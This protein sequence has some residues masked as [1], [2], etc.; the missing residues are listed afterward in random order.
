MTDPQSD[1][2]LVA[3]T[4]AAL[5]IG[6]EL[7]SG[8]TQE[9]NLIELAR[10]L[11]AI[12]I[13]LIRA[14]VVPDDID[15]IAA[16]VRELRTLAGVVFTSGGVGPT[17]DDVT[18][19]A[20]ARAF[21]VDVVLDPALADLVRSRYGE[22][23][24]ESH[25]RMARVPRGARLVSAV[26]IQWPTTL[27]GNVFVLP[28]VPEIFRMKLDAVRAHLAG[29]VPFVSRAVFLKSEEAGIK[30]LLD[31]VV[32]KY[33]DVD[34][35]SYPKWFEPAYS[36]KVTFDSRDAEAVERALLDFVASCDPAEVVRIQ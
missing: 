17:H 19:E 10:V 29:K 32:E 26:D 7:L 27:M 21:D 36:T 5:I 16:Q 3:S 23:C 34:V 6:N 15:V 12:G 1:E 35:G 9:A 8:K 22:A 13:P 11:R 33:P 2:R 24:T 31:R 4:A 18:I 28:G 14:V 25:L 20:V 30:P